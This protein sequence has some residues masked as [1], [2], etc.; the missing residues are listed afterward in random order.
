MGHRLYTADMPDTWISGL[1]IAAALGIPAAILAWALRLSQTPGGRA[2][3]GIVA[4]IVVGLL[5]GPGVLAHVRPDLHVRLFA[6]AAAERA[7]HDDMQQRQ[8]AD[9]KALL[10][11]GVTPAAVE[12]LRG[13]HAE[14]LRP[15]AEARDRAARAHREVLWWTASAA[16]ATYLALVGPS[17]V[18]RGSRAVERVARGLFTTRGNC[19]PVG[20]IA[21]ALAAAVPA[22]LAL[23][24][25]GASASGA[26]AWGLLVGVPGVAACLRPPVYVAG[27]VGAITAA[28][29]T[30]I[31]APGAPAAL[32]GAGLFIGLMAGLGLPESR[33]AARARR[34]ARSAALALAMPLLT[35][36]ACVSVDLALLA[37]RFPLAFWTALVVALV[38]SSDGRWAA[39]WLAWRGLRRGS[40]APTRFATALTN[41]GAGPAT[42]ALLIP[43]AAAEAITQPMLAG[44][45]LAAGVVEITRGAR[46]WLVRT[47]EGEP[48]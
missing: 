18:P 15:L 20:F 10:K 28:G 31:L 34:L 36:V 2:A 1:L 33:I 44:G 24:L 25:M 9:A 39:A 47:V 35:A 43:L 4:G 13:Q 23:W 19:F 41:A 22:A 7:A 17:L 6:G 21:V 12:E 37:G 40:P 3:A 32:V 42:L 14:A 11:V 5:A 46:A 38:F 26:I 8:D 48:R 30:M 29:L 45:L 16:L 27:A